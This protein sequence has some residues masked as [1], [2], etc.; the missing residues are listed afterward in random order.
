MTARSTILTAAL[1]LAL[2][3]SLSAATAPRIGLDVTAEAS[4]ALRGGLARKE[5]VHGSALLHAAWPGAE[6]AAEPVTW[7]GYVSLLGLAGQGPTERCLG[8]FLA[9]SNIEGHPGARLYSWWLEGVR[10][11]WSLR[12]GALLADE[13]FAGTESGGQFINSAQGWP[14]FISANTVNTGPAFFVAAP[15]LRLARTWGETAAWRFGIYD[16]DTFDSADGD[17]H[18]TRHGLHYR[19][20]GDQGWF[21]ITEA[22]VAAGERTRFKLGGWLHTATFPDLYAD[23]SGRP[24]ALTGGAPREHHGNH[25]IYAAVERTLAGRAGEPGALQAHVRA[26]FCPS[27]RSPLTAAFDAGIAWTGP[28]PGRPDDVLALGYARGCFGDD[29]AATA[30]LADPAAPAP[31]YEQVVELTYHLALTPRLTLQPDLQFI[32][33]P[34]G[35]AAARGIVAAFLRLSAAY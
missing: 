17:P 3:L 28:L 7:S 18:R 1:P 10:G 31:D 9:A 33:H 12:A 14:A 15:G 35:T 32:R 6:R 22:E 2:T 11:D 27:D 34:G 8:D 5:A 25:G 21:L 23:A 24:L 20:G 13:E 4:T 30:R 16:G 29:Y 26:G 19:V